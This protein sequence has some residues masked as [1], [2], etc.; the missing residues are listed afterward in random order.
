MCLCHEK[1]VQRYGYMTE[2]QYLESRVQSPL[3]CKPAH[4]RVQ[5]NP[6]NNPLEILRVCLQISWDMT[7]TDF[8]RLDT[9]G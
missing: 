5:R 3:G 1:V 2:Y 4:A 6:A 7:V 9:T 8:D